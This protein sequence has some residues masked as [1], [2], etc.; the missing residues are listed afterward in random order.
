MSRK[1]D[2]SYKP[3]KRAKSN[4]RD[5]P[6][7]RHTKESRLYDCDRFGADSGISSGGPVDHNLAAEW[8]TR[9]RSSVDLKQAVSGLAGVQEQVT[10]G[11]TTEEEQGDDTSSGEL[12][13]TLLVGD[14]Y[15][16]VVESEKTMATGG[17]NIDVQGKGSD[18]T[19]V[20][21]MQAMREDRLANEKKF[22]RLLTQLQDTRVRPDVTDDSD[23]D[24]N[25]PV[26]RRQGDRLL[27]NILIPIWV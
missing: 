22:E 11:A 25:R 2:N 20:T 10:E 1:Q 21:I 19:L 5:P 3:S 17:E 15:P 9:R 24:D 13:K 7:T 18:V 4:R 12:D 8:L 16:S 27:N 23:D 14:N 6:Q 26:R